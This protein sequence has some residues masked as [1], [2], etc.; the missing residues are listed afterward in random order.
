MST[1]EHGG[2]TG[3][4]RPTP[5]E[6]SLLGEADVAKRSLRIGRD[7][8][9]LLRHVVLALVLIGVGIALTY[10][11]PDYRLFPLAKFVAYFAAAAGLTVL[12]GLSGQ[13]SLGHGALMA[14]GGY[15]MAFTQNYLY[16]RGFTVAP[17]A[18]TS[19]RFAAAADPTAAPWTPLVSL[20]V[21]V[22]AAVLVGAMVGLAA[23]RLRGPYLAGV[24]LSI[25]II[26]YAVTDT[27]DVFNGN[28][29]L[30]VH[31]PRPPESLG[32]AFPEGQWRAWV[33]IAAAAVVVLFLAN[34]IRSRYG[35]MFRAVR[36][37][38]VAAQLSGIH[39]A[40]TQV[41][42][43]VV[44]AG[45]AGLAG[46][47]FVY[48]TNNVLPGYFDLNISL[49]LV[50]A[51]VVGGL[52]SLAGGAWGALFIVALPIATAELLQPIDASPAVKQQLTS[53]VPLALLG[54]ALII[55]TIAAPGGI[56][57]LVRRL[58]LRVAGRVRSR[59][60]QHT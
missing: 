28:Q 3:V 23:A 29:G 36:D 59:G 41:V 32:R 12:I 27:F 9:T 47:V 39:V 24:T 51:V 13:I 2:L 52:G 54:L 40:R 16:D 56:H 18:G 49:F 26:I 42:A 33:A 5:A 22:V 37:D 34:L 46:G 31:V 45:T 60:T 20:L 19:G 55:V 44:S 8:S 11:L 14:V 58:W 35:R 6:S 10:I 17:P 15:A 50:L 30:G 7:G 57:N 48:L 43:F 53:N 25:G 4:D 1:T 21:G 38:E